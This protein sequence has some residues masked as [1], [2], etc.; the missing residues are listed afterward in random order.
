MK[1]ALG[2]FSLLLLAA[3]C[4]GVT[5]LAVARFEDP[6]LYESVMTR[7]RDGGHALRARLED[8]AAREEAARE[9]ARERRRQEAE[10]REREE[11]ERLRLEAERRQKTEEKLR[12]LDAQ[13]AS[14][15]V[16]REKPPAAD[17]AVTELVTE[18][19][20]E[21]LTGGNVRLVYYN[22]G[23]AQWADQLY[24]N[25][26]IGSYGCGPTALAMAVESMTDA[27]ADPAS[28]AAWAA[29]AGYCAR[30]S[31]S[32]LSIVEG[33]AKRFGLQ[34]ESLGAA[35]PETLYAR[36]SEGGVAVALMGPGHFT[37]HGHFI[38]LHGVTLTG[39]ILAADPNSRENSLTVWDPQ[40][41]TD[42][43]S[44]SR[45]DG[46]PLWL[47]TVPDAL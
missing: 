10:R 9:A 39:G 43:L 44:R 38:L 11:Q 25:D 1:R 14:P 26:L 21:V 41:L 35:D 5:E 8:W 40:L 16:I 34:C 24:G 4:I 31:G 29:R 6:A 23:D 42:E 12:E 28:L 47:L 22:Q 20:Q 46:A 3:L 18:N 7:L 15:P 33:T 19:G 17:P 36:L 37:A 30:H 32:Y 13:M 27:D 45:H 2:V